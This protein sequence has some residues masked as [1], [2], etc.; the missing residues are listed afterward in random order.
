M[1]PMPDKVFLDTNVV[2]YAYSEDEMDKQNI[3]SEL[4]KRFDGKALI[5]KQV[6]NE[7][8]NILFKKF[9]LPSDTIESV[10]LELDTAFTIV[11]FDL[12]TQIKAIRLKQTYNLHY[13]DALI[14]A[15]ALENQCSILY[16]EDMQHNQVIDGSLTIINPFTTL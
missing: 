3:A 14:V 2:L 15:T 10:L 8:T 13:Y 11:D 7:L 4:L 9:K 12:R 5:S 16:S 1:K 6:I